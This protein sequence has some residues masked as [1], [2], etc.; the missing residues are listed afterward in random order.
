MRTLALLLL[1]TF[2][3]FAAFAAQPKFETLNVT[4]SGPTVK[5]TTVVLYQSTLLGTTYSADR[6]VKTYI[7]PP[8]TTTFQVTPGTYKFHCITKQGSRESGP[9]NTVTVK[10]Q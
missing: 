5:G 2:A 1:S 9:S 6:A 7:V 3:A 8:F 4:V 10:L